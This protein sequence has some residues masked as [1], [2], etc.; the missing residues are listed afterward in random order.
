MRAVR[1]VDTGIYAEGWTRDQAVAYFRESGCAEEPVIQAEVDRYI[2]WPA[3]GLSYK[4]GQLKILE[5]REHA[6]QRLGS[7]FDIR[8]FHDE[9]LNAGSLPLDVLEV[10][11]DRWLEGQHEKR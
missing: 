4:V 6:K 10:R 7:R 5:L 3:Q 2:A 9:V 11:I 1:L 8:T